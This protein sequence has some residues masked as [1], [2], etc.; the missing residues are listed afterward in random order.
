M[1]DAN[2]E[3]ESTKMETRIPELVKEVET[4]KISSTGRKVLKKL[5]LPRDSDFNKD[6]VGK[7]K[8][9][10]K[11]S[12]AKKS[13]WNKRVVD[14]K[15]KSTK[16]ELRLSYAYFNA[17]ICEGKTNMD[18]Q[19]KYKIAFER[20]KENMDLHIS[21]MKQKFRDPCLLFSRICEGR[22][23]YLLC[24]NLK[25][26]KG[27]VIDNIEAEDDS[28]DRYQ[29]TIFLLGE[30]LVDYLEYKKHP[31]L[32]NDAFSKVERLRMIWQTSNNGIDCG[33][34]LMR[35]MECF[36]GNGLSGLKCGFKKEGEVQQKQL[37][38]LRITYL[39]TFLLSDFNTLRCKVCKEIED[40]QEFPEKTKKIWKAEALKDI[41][42]RI[43]ERKDVLE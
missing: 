35:H 10:K 25:T 6:D 30:L 40:Y 1:E 20:F 29:E 31:H 15:T 17:C 8:R 13:P 16:E 39:N 32:K 7:G 2:E 28:I 11:P 19:D 33:I 42:K 43:E 21:T 26:N 12:F 27:Y 5:Q 24:F 9:E 23:Y 14:I 22:Q 37:N 34:F 18:T 4:P 38:C 36:M 41:E 3:P